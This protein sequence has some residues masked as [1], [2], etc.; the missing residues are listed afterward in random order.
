R[1]R[2][3]C[4]APHPTSDDGPSRRCRRSDCGSAARFVSCWSSHVLLWIRCPFIVLSR[5]ALDAVPKTFYI[6]WWRFHRPFFPRIFHAKGGC[7][8]RKKRDRKPA[9]ENSVRRLQVLR[10]G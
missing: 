1:Q 4:A 3:E 8:Q 5:V 2:R 7:S 6:K 9:G 10:A